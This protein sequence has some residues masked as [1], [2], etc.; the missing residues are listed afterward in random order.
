M[1][2]KLIKHLGQNFL[3]DKD[4]LKKIIDAADLKSSDII[5][6]IG[7]GTGILTFEL[8]K[9]VKQVIA[10]EK[11]KRMCEILE[12]E[13]NVRNVRN[14]KIIN[15]DIL[16]I[17]DVARLYVGRA[18]SYIPNYKIVANI[19]YYL[20]SPLIRK[21]LEAENQPKLMVLMVQKEVAQRICPPRRARSSGEAGAKPPKMSLLSIAVQFYAEAEIIAYVSK[22]SFYPVPKVDSAILKIEPRMNAN[23]EPNERELF[24]KLVKQGFSA[25]RKMLKNNLKIDDKILE[26]INL[27]P[28]IRAEGLSAGDWIKLFTLLKD[29]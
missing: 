23:L 7:P 15:K 24:F 16:K 28:K 26:K 2:M 1:K 21:F 14:V 19:P 6:E 12:N 9:R 10:V 4:V 20:T 5:L 18:T 8:A 13:L 3:T 11:D 27:N 25:K 22:N 29:A 17:E